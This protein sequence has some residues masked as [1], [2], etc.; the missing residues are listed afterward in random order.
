M[1]CAW[2]QLLNVSDQAAELVLTDDLYQFY[3]GPMG[4]R[5]S[6]VDNSDGQC[7]GFVPQLSN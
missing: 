1:T 5:R 6:A 7:L 2:H 3:L 4:N